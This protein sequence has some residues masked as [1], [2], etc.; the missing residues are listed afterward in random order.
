M[1]YKIKNFT[2]ANDVAVEM[3]PA[4]DRDG[5]FV[6]I[7]QFAGA[8][9]FNFIMRPDQARFMAASLVMAADECGGQVP[10]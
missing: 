1:K 2:E 10:A 8:M 6:M 4:S 9:S 7:T 5:P 3:L